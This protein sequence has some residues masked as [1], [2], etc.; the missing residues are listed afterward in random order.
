MLHFILLNRM[1]KCYFHILLNPTKMSVKKNKHKIQIQKVGK[2]RSLVHCKRSSKWKLKKKKRC[3][4]T[5]KQHLLFTEGRKFLKAARDKQVHAK[6]KKKKDPYHSTSKWNPKAKSLKTS[7]KKHVTQKGSIIRMALNFYS[8]AI[9]EHCWNLENYTWPSKCREKLSFYLEF[10]TQPN[11]QSSRWVNDILR[12]L[13]KLKFY[14]YTLFLR[15]LLKGIKTK[16]DS[17][18]T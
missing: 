7:R 4:H 8:K 18:R 17:K 16:Q 1:V 10:Y 13:R 15:K 3:E 5:L 11:Y 14:P 12:L 6:K 9:M 2:I